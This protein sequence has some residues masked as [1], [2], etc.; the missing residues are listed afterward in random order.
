MN[1]FKMVFAALTIVMVISFG[2]A[3]CQKSSHEHP[4]GEHPATEDSASDHPT[5]HP[6]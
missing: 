1:R 5:E 4:T 2:L 6:K 3:G